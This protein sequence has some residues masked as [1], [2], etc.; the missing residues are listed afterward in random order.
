LESVIKRVKSQKFAR[1]RVGICPTTPSGKLKIPTGLART[2]LLLKDFRESE[3]A[4]IKKLSKEIGE[5]LE[6][7][8]SESRAKAMTL[9]N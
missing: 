3:Y 6:V 7:M 8:A 9:Y 5:A 1:I 4:E 2:D